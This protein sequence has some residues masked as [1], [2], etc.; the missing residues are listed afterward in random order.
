MKYKLIIFDFDGTLADTFPFAL[1]VMDQVV[2]KFGLKKVDPNEIEMLRHFDARSVMKH[3]EIPIWKVPAISTHVMGLFGEQIHLMSLFQGIDQLLQDL[4]GQGIK[5]GVVTSNSYE[6]V[7][8]ILG[9]ENAALI[10]YYEC[11]VRI[12]GKQSKLKKVL[13]LS[14]VDATEAICIG[15]EIRDIQAAQKV[16]IP[17]GAVGWGFTNIEA[18][19]AFAPAEVFINVGE[20]AEK[21]I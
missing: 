13:K 5:L 17:F 19:K 4:S 11:G 21:L 7:C 12:F 2:E 3:F 8:K 16:N 6:N 15:D 18:L 10:E 1:K 20:I 14:G 9:P